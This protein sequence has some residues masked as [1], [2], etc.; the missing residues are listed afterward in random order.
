M[1]EKLT[2]NKEVCLGC[3]AC[4]GAYGDAFKFDDD[5]KAACVAPVDNA[6][7]VIA[8]CPVGAITK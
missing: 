4:V 1:A 6:D 3:G 2:V 8:V 5:G 7:E